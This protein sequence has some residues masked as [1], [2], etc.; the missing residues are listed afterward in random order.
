[1]NKAPAPEQRLTTSIGW[2]LGGVGALLTLLAWSLQLPP[3]P[4]HW[5]GN[6]RLGAA[7]VVHGVLW[8]KAVAPFCS[9]AGNTDDGL[10][11]LATWAWLVVLLLFQILSLLLLLEFGLGT[12][13]ATGHEW[14]VG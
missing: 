13:E 11:G 6:C 12:G 3:G 14:G 10:L 4:G 7:A 5:L 2:A 1:M 9:L 8:W